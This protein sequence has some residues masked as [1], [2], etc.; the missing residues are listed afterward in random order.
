MA[1]DASAPDRTPTGGP[2]D[3]RADAPPQPARTD[4]DPLDDCAQFLKGVG[5]E[6]FVL[7]ERLG[8][9]SVRDVL[10]F[11]PRDYQ[12]LTQVRPIGEIETGRVQTVRGRVVDVRSRQTRGGR[13]LVEIALAD[14]TGVL[15]CT[16]FNQPYMADKFHLDQW[17]MAN[18]KVR[19]YMGRLQVVSPRCD[20]VEPDSES[21]PPEPLVPVYALTEDLKQPAL[22][23]IVRGAVAKYVCL[24]PDVFT[25]AFR[26]ARQLPAL[27]ASVREVHSPRGHDELA[28]ARRRLVYEE[29]FLLELALALHRRELTDQR[30]AVAL[31]VDARVDARAR[32]LFPFSFTPGQEKAVADIRADLA[33]T[34]PMN[35]LLQGDV[36]S[37]KTAVAIYAML[38]AVAG[39]AQ[40]AMMAPTEVLALQHWRRVEHYLARSRVRRQLLTGAM[41]AAQRR[42]ALRGIAAGEI[43]LVIGTHAIIQ[44]DVVFHRLGLVV[45]DEQHKFGVRQRARVRGKGIDPHYLV[46]TATPIPR[47]LMLS[48]FGDL[49]ATTIDD[50][51]PGRQKVDTVRVAQGQEGHAL[52]SV[53]ARLGEGRQAYVVYPLVEQSDHLDLKAAEQEARRLQQQVFADFT[54][55]MVHG[56]MSQADKDRVMNDFQ[57]GRIHV[58]VATTVIEVGVDVPN[59]TAMIIEHADRFGLS[60][61]HQLR[62]R[63]ARGRHGG[64]CFLFGQA[65]T[66]DAERRLA[67]LTRTAD[68]FRIA[69]EDLKIRGP[70]QFFGT[71]Q[72]GLPE[73]RIGDIIEDYDLLKL[74]RKDA[75]AIVKLDPRLLNPDHQA[76]RDAVV[77]RFGTAL[78]LG[79]VG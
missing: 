26:D 64:T 40:A 56:R 57:K 33:R 35:R 69:E 43:D 55:G 63:I 51:P 79:N 72:H 61:L 58:L 10:E 16:W 54:V 22:R 23:R 14:D 47:T 24:L 19:Q 77:R 37:G 44:K 73:L 34:T 30:T 66:E 11:Y 38:T 50:L 49:D 46:M 8:L 6:R 9:H 17:L 71:R 74:A 4:S 2:T 78:S 12:D 3:A 25:P 31:P 7:L 60:Q 68:G 1:R 28:Q 29:F 48:V 67:T 41:P 53:R 39:K 59:A 62:G 15:S 75:F 13:H 18:G 5:P 27:S 45:V 76:M 21:G 32:R 42:E 65:S 36:G 20:V 52:A 70:G